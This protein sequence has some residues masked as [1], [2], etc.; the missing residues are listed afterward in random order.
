MV[1]EYNLDKGIF[2]ITHKENHNSNKNGWITISKNEN[3]D[4]LRRFVKYCDY[5][6]GGDV[7]RKFSIDKHLSQFKIAWQFIND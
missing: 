7:E 3:D 1:L 5:C 6:T 4:F 2:H